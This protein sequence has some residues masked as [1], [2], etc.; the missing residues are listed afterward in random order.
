MSRIRDISTYAERAV[1]DE[2][3]AR[4]E[5]ITLRHLVESPGIDYGAMLGEIASQLARGELHTELEAC[6]FDLLSTISR[7]Q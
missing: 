5:E 4:D 3:L 1:I 6:H 2:I 7:R